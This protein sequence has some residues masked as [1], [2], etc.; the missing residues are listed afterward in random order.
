YSPK[1]VAPS[2][3][4]AP[5]NPFKPKELDE[6]GIEKQIQDFV[7]CSLLAQVAEYD[8]V[9]IMGSE[10]YFINQFL[11]AHTNHRTDRWGGSYENR[12]RLAV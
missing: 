8:G 5:I 7:T 10:G 1:Q 3:I 9:E 12:M 6:E 11:A 4:Q 2:A